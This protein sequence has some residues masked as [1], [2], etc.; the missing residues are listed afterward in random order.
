[1]LQ[2]EPS[3]RLGSGPRDAE[4]IKEH[5]YFRKINWENVF[6]KKIP[7]PKCKDYIK[8][9]QFFPKAKSF[10]PDLDPAGKTMN[11]PGWSFI[12]NDNDD[13]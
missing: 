3:K 5:K 13:N 4:E 7:P 12:N 2:K 9:S 8:S 1:M 10:K 11:L 6:N